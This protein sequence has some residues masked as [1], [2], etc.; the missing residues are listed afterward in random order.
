MT[1]KPTFN[2]AYPEIDRI[3]SSRR[4]A[5]TYLSILPWEDVRQELLIRIY[6]KWDKYD[7]QK[8]PKLENWI[9]TVITNALLNLRRDNLLRLARPCIGGG[10]TNG[11]SCTY[12]TGGDSCSFTPSGKQ[13]EECPVFLDWKQKRE[14]QFNV[15][16]NVSLENHSQEVSNI[17]EDF[18]DT[19]SIKCQV[20]TIMI[21]Q[22]TQWEAKIYRLLFIKHMTPTEVSE[23]LIAS[24]K[25][26]K[27]PL[28]PEEKTNYQ[29]VLA[30]QR[31]FKG[32]MREIL[33][34]EGHL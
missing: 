3:V 10:K 28:R 25:K 27:R 24:S 11:K 31:E 30:M 6:N 19:N 18:M 16:S 20:D 22:L 4:G 23:Q 34:R 7:P 5:W 15:K 14:A 13:C 21:K 8:A 33:K 17:Q 12:N 29:S 26:R 9:N 1:N 2:E 32:M